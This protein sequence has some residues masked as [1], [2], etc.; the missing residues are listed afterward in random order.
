[1]LLD[2]WFYVDVS[3]SANV[4]FPFPQQAFDET[5]NNNA[6]KNLPCL[7]IN[8]EQFTTYP[9]LWKA[10]KKLVAL[11]NGSNSSN[12]KDSDNKRSELHVIKDT[13]HQN[14]CDAVFWL[15]TFVLRRVLGKAL[16][17]KDPVEAYREIVSVSGDFL[18]RHVQPKEKTN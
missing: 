18:V 2:G 3:E 7:F 15:P 9:K 1:M 12:D 10:T 17:S 11:A 6:L 16:G 8:S 4:E 14:F 5:D 13:G